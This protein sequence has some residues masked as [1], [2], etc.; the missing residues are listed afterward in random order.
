MDY[1]EWKRS[2]MLKYWIKTNLKTGEK[3]LEPPT[4]RSAFQTDK[5]Y[6]VKLSFGRN[7]NMDNFKD[8]GPTLDWC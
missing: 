4:L 2:Y 5:I 3:S 8:P 1:S 6:F 7:M